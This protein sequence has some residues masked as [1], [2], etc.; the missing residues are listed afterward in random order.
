[1][2]NKSFI[3][4]LTGLISMIIACAIFYFDTRSSVAY[5]LFFVGFVLVGIG[6]L[7]GLFK[8]VKDN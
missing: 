1:M 4:I 3:T 6:I 2:F 7:V 5:A 8:M